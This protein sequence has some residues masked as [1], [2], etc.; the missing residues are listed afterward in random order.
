M[1][2]VGCGILDLFEFFGL[3]SNLRVSK[4][5]QASSWVSLFG[6]YASTFLHQKL[7]LEF[8]ALVD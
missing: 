4:S 7:V 1:L 2:D 5:L 8:R 3:G 6:S